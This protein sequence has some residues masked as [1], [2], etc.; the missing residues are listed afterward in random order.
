MDI[1]AIA[2]QPDIAALLVAYR[3]IYFQVYA[4]SLVG[5]DQPMYADVYFRVGGAAFTFYKT[6]TSFSI[7][8]VGG[9]NSVFEFDTQDALQEYL[10]T[11]V[12]TVP[13]VTSIFNAP[14]GI[15]D[16]VVC[17]RGSTFTGGV[18]VPNPVVPVQGTATTPPSAGGGIA[19]NVFQVMNATLAPDY[20]NDAY[21]GLNAPEPILAGLVPFTPPLSDQRIYG[22]TNLPLNPVLTPN[23][24]GNPEVYASDHGALPVLFLQFGS[25]SGLDLFSRVCQLNIFYI[26]EGA[27]FGAAVAIDSPQLIQAPGVYYIASGLQ[28]IALYAPSIIPIIINPANNISYRMY[29]EDIDSGHLCWYSPLYKVMNKTVENTRLWFQNYWG[30]FEQLSFVRQSQTFKTTSSEQYRPLLADLSQGNPQYTGRQRFNVRVQDE[31]S[32]MGI[33]PEGLMPWIKEL[34]GSPFV[35]MDVA[36]YPGFPS[37]AVPLKG[38]KVEDDTFTT[39]KTIIDGRVYYEI[40]VKMPPTMDYITLR[41]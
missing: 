21:N 3:P 24:K 9:T 10:L 14:G 25:Y 13:A 1:G 12:P 40:T 22:L 16:V 32:V 11:F 18:L 27:A 29:I 6:F 20:I 35:F 2:I 37:A 5:P 41:N 19:S 34:L 26:V 36:G 17:F 23:Y 4:D 30:H 15:T 7:S 31:N 33:F 28:D 38:F 8:N 39:R